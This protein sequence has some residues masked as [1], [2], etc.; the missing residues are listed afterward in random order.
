MH[1]FEL[2]AS[3]SSLYVSRPLIECEEF[4]AWVQQHFDK[5]LSIDKFHVTIVHAKTP[6]AWNALEPQT[7]TLVVKG[8]KRAL[9]PLGDKG[10]V[11]LKFASTALH[12]RWQE[13]CE[14]GATWDWESYQPHVTITYDGANLDLDRILPYKGTLTFGAEEFEPVTEYQPSEQKT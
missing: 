3:P 2:F 4:Y 11:V 14:A 13:F 8:G 5:S 7:D 6:F 10:T 1:L 9:T 12:A